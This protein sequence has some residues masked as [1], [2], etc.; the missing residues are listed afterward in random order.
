M[1]RG[2]SRNVMRWLEPRTP[3]PCGHRVRSRAEH[4]RPPPSCRDSAWLSS[5]FGRHR[6]AQGAEGVPCCAAPRVTSASAERAAAAGAPYLCGIMDAI[7]LTH[8]YPYEEINDYLRVHPDSR[9]EVAEALAYFEP[10]TSAT[11]S[12]VRLW[13]ISDSRT[14]SA[15]PKPGTRCSRES[16][17]EPSSSTRTMAMATMPAGISHSAVIERFF[18]QHL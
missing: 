8:T 16:V 1:R 7:A 2:C 3:A 15:R 18:A 12:P 17:P 10:S 9:Q 11:G 6:R 4:G 14:T 5:P 13:S